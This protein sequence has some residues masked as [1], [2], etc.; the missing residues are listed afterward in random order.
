MLPASF[1]IIKVDIIVEGLKSRALAIVNNSSKIVSQP[2]GAGDNE[3]GAKKIVV[4]V[5]VAL[6][7]T[8]KSLHILCYVI[9]SIRQLWQGTIKSYK[10][11]YIGDKCN[12]W[13]CNATSSHRWDNSA[14]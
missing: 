14:A 7:A 6:E 12:D 10:L 8:G 2:L 3:L 1:Y 13:I 5:L 4:V 11:V 9:D